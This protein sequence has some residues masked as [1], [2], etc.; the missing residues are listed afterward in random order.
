MKS[1]ARQQIRPEPSESHPADQR[2]KVLAAALAGGLIGALAVRFTRHPQAN[3]D[4]PQVVSIL[5]WVL[6]AIYWSITA[7]SAPAKISESRGS[8]RIHELLVNCGYL[9]LFL[10]SALPLAIPFVQSRFLPPS[11]LW[12]ALGL[13][14]QAG[15]FGLAVWARRTLG[16]NWSAPIEIKLDHQLVR[17][18]PYRVLRHPIY[19]AVLG[20]AAGTVL[21][22]GKVPGLFAIAI[23]VF[24]YIR[25]IRLE[26][27]RLREAF[28]AE[29]DEYRRTAWGLVPGL[30]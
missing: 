5:G 1:I 21:T 27:A 26:E 22:I 12:V 15:S 28:G 10:P 30:F 24:A 17:T 13:A 18:G 14:V 20:M 11:P 25:K 3:S 2:K 9:L 4:W 19:T 7:S 23:I 8:R 6:F 16:R 29:Y